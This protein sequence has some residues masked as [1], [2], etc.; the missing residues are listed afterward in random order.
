MCRKEELI[1]FRAL[2]WTQ[3][4]WERICFWLIDGPKKAMFEYGLNWCHG[5]GGSHRRMILSSFCRIFHI[6]SSLTFFLCRG[7]GNACTL[8]QA[9]V[10]TTWIHL[11]CATEKPVPETAGVNKCSQSALALRGTT[12]SAAA[13]LSVAFRYVATWDS[14]NCSVERRTFP[15]AA[16]VVSAGNNKQ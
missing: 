15:S 5:D 11:L 14:G 2:N 9:K 8:I 10:G 1:C 3:Q 13:E 16:G 4:C 7:W 12:R 6:T